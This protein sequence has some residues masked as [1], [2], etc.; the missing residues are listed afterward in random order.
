ML[1]IQTSQRGRVLHGSR[2]LWTHPWSSSGATLLNRCQG[3]NPQRLAAGWMGQTAYNGG[4]WHNLPTF[5][6]SSKFKP[7]GTTLVIA[8]GCTLTTHNFDQ[9]RAMPPVQSDHLR[10]GYQRVRFHK[11]QGNSGNRCEE[12]GPQSGPSQPSRDASANRSPA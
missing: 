1:R 10:G 7:R 8:D 5:L 12:L 6:A 3:A 4:L 2:V 9:Y 11:T